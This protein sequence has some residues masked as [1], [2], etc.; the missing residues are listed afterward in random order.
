MAQ[1]FSLK[2]NPIFQKFVP[3]P[4]PDTSMP[5]GETQEIQ[6]T[7]P[8]GQN[9]RVKERPSENDAHMVL[10]EKARDTSS[11]DGF[12]SSDQQIVPA[13]EDPQEKEETGFDG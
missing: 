2:D 9:L 6:E 3:Y 12:I 10:V 1:R 5:V 4:P 11:V 13:R 7:T 8:E